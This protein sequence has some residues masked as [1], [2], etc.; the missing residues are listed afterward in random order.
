M[1]EREAIKAFRAYFRMRKKLERQLRI[2]Q[3]SKDYDATIKALQE[4][5]ALEVDRCEDALHDS[6]YLSVVASYE[7]I[8]KN[9]MQTFIELSGKKESELKEAN[10]QIG[11][12]KARLRHYES[13]SKGFE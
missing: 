10:A 8:Q 13:G 9:L 3:R 12:L 11:Y 7:E 5:Q 2:V 6:L 1:T 4:F